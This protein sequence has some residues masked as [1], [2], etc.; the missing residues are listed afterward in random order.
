MT[1]SAHAASGNMSRG[2]LA[3]G[4]LLLRSGCRPLIMPALRRA[5]I[6]AYP[7]SAGLGSRNGRNDGQ[8]LDTASDCWAG[9]E[10]RESTV[11]GKRSSC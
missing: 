2:P 5:E 7:C 11:V 3:P 4:D 6:T 8:E 1:P 10:C 9:S